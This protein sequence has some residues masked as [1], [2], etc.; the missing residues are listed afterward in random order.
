MKPSIFK[1]NNKTNYKPT[2]VKNEE[3]VSELSINW[4]E[5]KN[6]IA[7]VS[8]NVKM[9]TG[10][11]GT[12]GIT[13]ATGLPAPKVNVEMQT[14]LYDGAD[15]NNQSIR[16]RISKTGTLSWWYNPAVELTSSNVISINITY[17]VA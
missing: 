10:S 2:V 13:L 8:M 3:N 14:H 1:I 9:A 5:V 16:C 7:Y 15:K 17:P 11:K 6:N 12:A 4:C